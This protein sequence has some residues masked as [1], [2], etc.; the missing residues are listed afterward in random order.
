MN[1]IDS[2]NIQNFAHPEQDIPLKSKNAKTQTKQGD[3]VGCLVM[4]QYCL[5]GR[6]IFSTVLTKCVSSNVVYLLH[7]G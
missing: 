7:K 6:L 1:A 3:T 5:I 2:W 4:T